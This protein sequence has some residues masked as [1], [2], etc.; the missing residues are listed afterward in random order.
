VVAMT[1]LL[2]EDWNDNAPSRIQAR[3]CSLPPKIDF[4]IGSRSLA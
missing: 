4:A 3:S 1:V 2:S